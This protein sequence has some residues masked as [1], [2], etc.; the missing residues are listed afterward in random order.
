MSKSSKA[1]RK[2]DRVQQLEREL[3]MEKKRN[4]ELQ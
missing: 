4:Q 1:E 2:E 3:S